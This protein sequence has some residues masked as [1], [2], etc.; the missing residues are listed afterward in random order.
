MVGKKY[1]NPKRKD[2]A[3]VQSTKVIGMMMMVQI[4]GQSDQSLE[5]NLA[6]VTGREAHHGTV[7]PLEMVKGLIETD[8]EVAENIETGGTG[9]WIGIGI[10][11]EAEKRIAIE[12]GRRG[13]GRIDTGAQTGIKIGTETEMVAVTRIEERVIVI[14]RRRL[15][16]TASNHIEVEVIQK[17]IMTSKLEREVGIGRRTR[18]WKR[19]I[20]KTGIA[21]IYIF[22][23]SL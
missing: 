19:N 6:T 5:R 18:K 23:S 13:M 1:L 4:A 20:E 10:G 2:V 15:I 22:I 7:R 9:T 3:G 12:I 14:M 21:H 8:P 16:E 17:D 11:K